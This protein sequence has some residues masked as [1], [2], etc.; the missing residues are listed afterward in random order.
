MI[1][2]TKYSNL[3]QK[4]FHFNLKSYTHLTFVN[5]SNTPGAK[6]S[7]GKK[8]FLVKLKYIFNIYIT[9]FS[10]NILTYSFIFWIVLANLQ[11]FA[12]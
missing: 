11:I 9:L 5:M 2:K 1:N 3:S 7:N 4:V 6:H 8:P 12:G 10:A